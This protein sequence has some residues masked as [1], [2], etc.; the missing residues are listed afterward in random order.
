MNLPGTGRLSTRPAPVSLESSRGRQPNFPLSLG[1]RRRRPM[2]K[3]IEF[4]PLKSI[5]VPNV[6]RMQPRGLVVVIGPNSSGKT[7]MLKDMLCLLLGQPR[8]LVV[9]EEIELQRPS[10]IEPLLEQLYS[11]GHIRK[12]VDQHNRTLIRSKDA[13]LWGYISSQ[14]GRCPRPRSRTFLR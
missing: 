14:T 2:E 8:K 3:L 5:A 1:H 12:K 10:A 13:S 11:E 6:G 9:C 7:Q 4:N